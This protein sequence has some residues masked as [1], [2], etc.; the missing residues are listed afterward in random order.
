MNWKK[1]EEF[2]KPKKKKW[3]QEDFEDG[4]YYKEFLEDWENCRSRHQGQVDVISAFFDDGYQ[5]IF[6]KAGRKFAKTTTDIDIGWRYAAEAP[7]RVIYYCYPTIALGI[8]VLWEEQRL[9]RCDMR[10]DYMKKYV[11]KTDDNKHLIKFVNGSF[12][13]LIGTWSEAR[14]RG[15]QPDL[16]IVD[17]IQDCS[18]EYLDAMDPNLA[19]KNGR[20]VMSGTPP[21]KRNHWY[22]WW[23]R[24]E[25]NTRGKTFHF[26]SY[27]NKSLPHLEEWLDRKH[28]E[29]VKAGKEDEWL[30]EYMAEDCFSSADRVLPDANFM[31]EEDINNVLS[32]FAY[33][34]RI[35]IRAISMQGQ[36]LSVV[37]AILIKR[38][39]LF[40]CD[41]AIYPQIWNQSMTSIMDEIEG[42][43]RDIQDLCA[44]RMRNL[45]WDPTQSFQ[46]VIPGFSKCRK[47]IQWQH[48][49][50]PLLR[51]MMLNK[52]IFFS[53]KIGDF[54]LECQNL[55]R[56]EK[57]KEIEVNYPYI[58]TLSMMINEYF[59]S[60]KTIKQSRE[61]ADKYEALREMGILPPQ[62]KRKSLFR[63]GF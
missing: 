1:N 30:R 26:T 43:T 50:I 3:S 46:D 6:N 34:D 32:N 44:N 42:Q 31:A 48:R 15:T 27:D 2:T 57:I 63:I 7:G 38:K 5:Y 60:E 33:G 52:K 53:E 8:E 9:Q 19:A 58:C 25:D 36:Y 14:G 59:S 35:P 20:C 11:E 55:L 45:V 13:K 29:L 49:G 62:K 23:D 10:T 18:G 12:M 28:V 41:C 17:E 39:M 37:F 54:G 21:K 51:E 47:D 56:D 61:E 22:Q 4:T 24:I 16:L 40:V